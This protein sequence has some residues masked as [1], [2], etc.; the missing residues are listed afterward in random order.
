MRN[1]RIQRNKKSLLLYLYMLIF[2][3][4]IIFYYTLLYFKILYYTI[5]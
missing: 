2:N 1:K 5:Y 4:Y 3:I